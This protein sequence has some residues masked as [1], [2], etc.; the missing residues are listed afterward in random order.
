MDFGLQSSYFRHLPNSITISTQD[1]HGLDEVTN[2][3][4][5]GI[6]MDNN[7]TIGRFLQLRAGARGVGYLSN[8]L[9]KVLFGTTFQPGY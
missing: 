6:Y 7:W 5:T 4:E 8:G 9:S 2:S 3:L 1:R